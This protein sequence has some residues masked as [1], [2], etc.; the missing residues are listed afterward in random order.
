MEKRRYIHGEFTDWVIEPE[1]RIYQIFIKIFTMD[2]IMYPFKRAVQS[3]GR[4]V[5]GTMV[6][7]AYTSIE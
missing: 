7:S 5:L 1:I 2:F 3:D 4:H 6:I